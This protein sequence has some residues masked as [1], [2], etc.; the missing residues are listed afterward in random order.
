MA[1]KTP[2][3]WRGDR[4]LLFQYRQTVVSMSLASWVVV[5]S[6]NNSFVA[7][8]QA[9]FLFMD[10]LGS[11]TKVNGV[12]GGVEIPWCRM[13]SPPWMSRG[14][15]WFL[16]WENVRGFSQNHGT[17]LNNGFLKWKVPFVIFVFSLLI[18]GDFYI[19]LVSNVNHNFSPPI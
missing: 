14:M 6:L 12:L 7:D 18:V 16:G 2:W 5:W 11:I 13:K 3:E 15:W 19:L 10:W 9:G 8:G 1:P 4:H 17:W